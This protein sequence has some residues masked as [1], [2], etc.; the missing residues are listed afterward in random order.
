M[1][2]L[3]LA[4]LVVAAFIGGVLDA[5][6]GGGGF[7]VIPAIV[8]SGS[9]MQYAIG[10]S[11]LIFLMDSGSAMLGHARRSN[12]D[13]KLAATYGVFSIAGTQFGAYVSKSLPSAML[14]KVFG[15]F[16]LAMLLAIIL[17]P[18][19]G[20]EKK[21]PKSRILAIPAGLLMGFLIGLFGGGVGVLIIVALVLIS[22]AT[23]LS[24]SGTSQV[25]VFMSN[26]FAL[27]A[28]YAYGLVDLKL[29]LLMGV[30][31][32]FG[33]QAGVQLAHRYGSGWL[34]MMLVAVTLAS[35]VKLIL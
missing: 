2:F 18:R 4:F 1:D 31:A 29:G 9:V 27:A 23:L 25:I 12:I 6:V 15:F 35:S 7:L 17:Q 34:R 11:R 14:A 26:V 28:Y 3:V 22:G 21:A 33:A 5:T 13:Y 20:L 10:T 19:M 30:A 8:F 32:F 24:A 16:M